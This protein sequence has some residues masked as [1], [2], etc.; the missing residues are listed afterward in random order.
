M[1]DFLKEHGSRQAFVRTN[2]TG[3]NALITELKK[4]GSPTDNT[5]L[6]WV[7]DMIMLQQQL[8]PTA[9]SLIGSIAS[10]SEEGRNEAFCGI[11]CASR[12]DVLS[13]FDELEI[14]DTK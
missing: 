7:Q 8:R 9:A 5:A 2:P 1:Y 4:T 11:C 10:A 6:V 3:T 14:D 13:D 12:D